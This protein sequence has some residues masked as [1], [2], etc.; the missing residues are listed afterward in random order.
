MNL[1]RAILEVLRDVS[2]HLMTTQAVYSQVRL[3]TGA[4]KTLT[5]VKAKRESLERK[6]QANGIEHEDYGHRWA[7]TDAGKMRLAE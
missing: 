5:D 3:A 2:G 7:I 1:E 4:D 6:G